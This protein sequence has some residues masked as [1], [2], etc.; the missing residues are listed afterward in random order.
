MLRS[1]I[2]FFCLV[3]ALFGSTPSVNASPVSP[4]IPALVVMDQVWELE[5]ADEKSSIQL[6]YI[7]Q[8]A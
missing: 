3:Y 5:V 1:A 4:A 2:S 7:S 8:D 6:P